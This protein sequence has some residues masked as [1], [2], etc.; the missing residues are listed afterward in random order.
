VSWRN[1]AGAGLRLNQSRR[2]PGWPCRDVQDATWQ[3]PQRGVLRVRGERGLGVRD[4][5][6]S[7]V[8]LLHGASRLP[9][10]VVPRVR[11]VLPPFDGA[12]L[13]ALT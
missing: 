11:D 13:P 6:P 12:L 7:R 5:L 2:A 3:L 1:K 10:G 8:F 4:V 9:C